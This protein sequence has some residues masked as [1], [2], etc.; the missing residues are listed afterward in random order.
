[1]APEVLLDGGHSFE[2]D[3][4]S[5]GNLLFEILVGS[6]PFYHPKHTHEQTKQHILHS[7]LRFP[8]NL[9]L[10]QSVVSLIT[11]LLQ[12]KPEDR[13]GSKGGIDEILRH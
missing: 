7:A 1:M 8:D 6:P 9:S 3:Y 13:L 5:I 11:A 4:Y 2:V 10:S 12:K